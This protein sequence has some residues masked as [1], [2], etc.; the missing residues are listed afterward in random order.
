MAQLQQPISNICISNTSNRTCL[1]RAASQKSTITQSQYKIAL[2]QAQ[3][4]ENLSKHSAEID[5]VNVSTEHSSKNSS[6]SSSKYSS[7]WTKAYS[8]FLD[9]GFNQIKPGKTRRFAVEG[10]IYFVSAVVLDGTPVYINNWNTQHTEFE[11]NGDDLVEINVKKVEPP[12]APCLK[13]T[14]YGMYYLEG[15][16]T[17]TVQITTQNRII[18]RGKFPVEAEAIFYNEYAFW[19]P[20]GGPN[21]TCINSNFIL[22]NG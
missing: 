6:S 5:K 19:T 21:R 8:A 13:P 22:C 14:I 18:R 20:G 11:F 16:T 12:P 4:N 7:S 10:K 3:S 17:Q 9:E 2:S 15:D 1:I